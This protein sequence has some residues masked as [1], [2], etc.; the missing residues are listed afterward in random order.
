VI[1]ANLSGGGAAGA[2]AAAGVVV[3]NGQ[4]LAYALSSSD[5]KAGRDINIHAYNNGFIN[6]DTISGAGAV[7]LE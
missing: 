1:T 2:G 5:L 7:Q 3:I 4:T 6:V